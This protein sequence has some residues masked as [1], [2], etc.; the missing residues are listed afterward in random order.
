MAATIPSL[1]LPIGFRIAGSPDLARPAAVEMAARAAE[2][3][4]YAAVWV[5]SEDPDELV[6]VATVAAAATEQVRIGVALLVDADGLRP[7]QRA[8]LP[9]LNQLAPGR[10]TLG[11]AAAALPAEAVAR[12]IASVRQA[13]AP[14]IEMPRLVLSASTPAVVDLVGQEADGWLADGV[15]VAELPARWAEV[16]AAADTHGR[17]GALALVVPAWVELYEGVRPGGRVDYQGDLA[18]VV[19]DVLVAARA[20]AEEV[21]LMPGGGPSLDGLLDVSARVAEALEAAFADAG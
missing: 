21:V 3:L 9:W 8:G 13:C 11:I 10:L 16:Q 15:P 18:Q 7:D 19:A 2:S 12:V 5:V 6:S 14:N 1:P 17:G 4:G 20:G